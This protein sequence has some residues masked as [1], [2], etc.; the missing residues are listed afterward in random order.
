MKKIILSL[1]FLALICMSFSY[2]GQT[3]IQGSNDSDSSYLT[4]NTVL[5][6]NKEYD[7]V[8]GINYDNGYSEEHG[9]YIFTLSLE[10]VVPDSNNDYIVSTFNV[11]SKTKNLEAG[12]YESS[13]ITEGVVANKFSYGSSISTGAN[14]PN[15]FLSKGKLEISKTLNNEFKVDYIGKKNG[16]NI[17]IHFEGNLQN[18]ALN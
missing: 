6:N 3:P 10:S 5:L 17:K 14:K 7:L 11:F 2:K 16:S 4:T 1:T 15:V 9:V 13:S 8:K 12:T 18:K